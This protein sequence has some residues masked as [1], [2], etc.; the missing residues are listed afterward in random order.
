MKQ[1]LHDEA[2]KQFGRINSATRDERDQCFEDRR[3]VNIAGAQWDGDFAKNFENKP[4]LEVNKIHLSTLRI[5]N[6][7]RN[8][9]ISVDFTPRKGGHD[10]L[11]ELCD[12]LYR[13]DEV[14]SSAEEA[15][16]NAFKEMVDGGM[17]AWRL[18]AEYEDEYDEDNDYQRI[19]FEPI[20]DADQTLF[21][22]VDSNKADRS[23]A[24]HAFLLHPMSK[25][26]YEETYGDDPSS[27]PRSTRKR[28]GF[29]WANREH[30]YIAEYYKVEEDAKETYVYYNSE[31]N[32]GEE[33]KKFKLSDLTAD[34]KQE[35]VDMG[36]SETRRRRVKCK[37]V[38]KYILSG[39]EILE[40]CGY[41]AGTEIPF[42]PA[43]GKRTV[44]D[45]IERISGHVRLCKDAQRLKN[46]Q[47]SKLAEISALSGVEKP[48][49][50]PEQVKGQELRWA[51]DNIKN[52]PYQT[53]NPIK[54]EEGQIV[55]QGPIGF[56]KPPQVPPTLAAL[57]GVTEEDMRDILGN[58]Q[59]GEDMAS[60]ISG[61]AVEMIQTRLDM[62]TF[63]FM[64]NFKKA[65]KRCGQ[66]YLGMAKDLY[67]EEGRAMKLVDPD[68]KQSSKTLMQK[69][70]NED[71]ETYYENDIGSVSFDVTVDVGPSSS[72][73]RSALVKALTGML[74]V[75]SDPDTKV[76][77]EAL[78]MMN[79]EGEGLGDVRESFRKKLVAMGHLE[80]NEADIRAQQEA[81][82][83]QPT[84]NDQ[85]L[86]AE[87]QKA[88]AE[89]QKVQVDIMETEA[90]AML[91]KAQA[92]EIMARANGEPT[93][94]APAPATYEE[95]KLE[96]EAAKT[97][98]ELELKERELNRTLALKEQELLLKAK[99]QELK[100]QE[101]TAKLAALGVKMVD[102]EA[103][104]ADVQQ[105]HQDAVN[106]AKAVAEAVKGIR[107]A[108]DQQ[109][110]ALEQQ[111]R[112]RAE[113]L[114]KLDEPRE[115]IR[116][117]DGNITG[118][119]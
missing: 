80:P 48:I 27:W 53:V 113:A 75:T 54:N 68:G 31:I 49:F 57:L 17:G 47:L 62:Q 64:S 117:E 87:A 30:V 93:P 36:Y 13:A 39:K 8:N 119:K 100:E 85:Y 67:I 69:A 34:D 66:I 91:K 104:A 110:E 38:R 41:I 14:D 59:Q 12:G 35:L 25:E 19:R 42:I 20:Y 33:E 111:A 77:L 73:K 23:D 16:D 6:E 79:L 51:R 9:R 103:K 116:D 60:N 86:M 95:E 45:G 5:E 22:D 21:F 15:R 81:G 114:A 63:I 97:A 28:Q 88:Q 58:Q 11:A 94:E 83:P 43:Y 115:V 82:P 101:N 37:K 26:K 89:A 4:K 90:N 74:A 61:K 10:N 78:V 24:K 18:R 108:L 56:T 98:R 106:M 2:L 84:P 72:S 109:N 71:G 65:E 44:I 3:F 105:G 52:Y 112:D 96:M 76:V 40:D 55:H 99:E 70:I 46:M 50:A 29:E 32:E 1:D 107:P 7:Y 118:L 92:A 102:E